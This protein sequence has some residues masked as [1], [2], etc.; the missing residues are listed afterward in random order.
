MNTDNLLAILPVELL[1]LCFRPIGKHAIVVLALVSRKL[2]DRVR[3]SFLAGKYPSRNLGWYGYTFGCI[4][5]IGLYIQIVGRDI[6][7]AR[8][9]QIY[10]EGHGF[11]I[12]DKSNQL[13]SVCLTAVKKGHID[14]LKWVFHAEKF[15]YPRIS[16]IAAEN[17]LMAIVKW[18]YEIEKLIWKDSEWLESTYV[19]R[20]W[21]APLWF[22]EVCFAAASHGHLSILEWVKSLSSPITNGNSLI[23]L[24]MEA[25]MHYAITSGK[26]DVLRWSYENGQKIPDKVYMAAVLGCMMDILEWMR[27]EYPGWDKAKCRAKAMELKRDTILAWLDR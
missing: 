22:N 10:L 25:V 24:A 4:D 7:N 26:L 20:G 13:T 11:N 8:I 12:N 21:L 17:N 23:H 19:A 1:L 15:F 5:T 18:A 27:R 6:T 16:I 3:T 9:I 2:W 14:V